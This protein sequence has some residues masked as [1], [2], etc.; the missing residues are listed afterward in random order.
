MPETINDGSSTSD[1]SVGIDQE[2]NL[3]FVELE[4]VE[5]N[6]T[7]VQVYA[8][9]D[10]NVDVTSYTYNKATNKLSLRIDASKGA[11][12]KA[13]LDEIYNRD[14]TPS[15][16]GYIYDVFS[17]DHYY[18]YWVYEI[19]YTISIGGGTPIESYL[20]VPLGDL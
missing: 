20:T 12:I 19:Y 17:I 16:S 3:Q 11:E 13:R 14:K 8:F 5:I 18:E 4:G 1:C 7:K 15:E 6:I 10:S 2:I 9:G